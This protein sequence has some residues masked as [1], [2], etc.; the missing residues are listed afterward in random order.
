MAADGN[1]EVMKTPQRSL[2]CAKTANGS[3]GVHA[4][5]MV[6]AAQ[7][8]VRVSTVAT[9]L[10]LALLPQQHRTPRESES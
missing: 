8:R 9:S 7:N 6:Q 10:V 4:L 5:P 1:Q 2:S 3:Q